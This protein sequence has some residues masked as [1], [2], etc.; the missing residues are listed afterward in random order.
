MMKS[1]CIY[2]EP[3]VYVDENQRRQTL[4]SLISKESS[5][6]YNDNREDIELF[7]PVEEFSTMKLAFKP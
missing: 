5:I 6:L 3:M 2:T 1:K 7:D 4:G